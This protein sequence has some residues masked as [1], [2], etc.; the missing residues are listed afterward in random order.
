[1]RISPFLGAARAL[2]AAN[3]DF[4]LSSRH[5]DEKS[6]LELETNGVLVKFMMSIYRSCL[7][8]IGFR[9]FL[10]REIAMRFPDE[11]QDGLFDSLV[12]WIAA[13]NAEVAESDGEL[14]LFW[15]PETSGSEI[16][17]KTR[18]IFFEGT[19][20]IELMIFEHSC[21]PPVAK[22][23]NHSHATGKSC[24]LMTTVPPAAIEAMFPHPRFSK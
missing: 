24:S 9:G 8:P 7:M 2:N 5:G 10:T 21:G 13:I 20:T 6:A 11:G 16:I 12:H 23:V 19:S 14:D 4:Q 17:L 1:V 15:Y 18:L 22:V 3:C